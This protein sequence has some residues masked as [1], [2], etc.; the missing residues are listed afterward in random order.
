MAN[1]KNWL[2]VLVIVLVFG[3]TVV[4]CDDGS[5]GSGGGNQLVEEWYAT[6]QDA[7]AGISSAV[8]YQFTSDGKLWYAGTDNKI[9]YTVSGNTITVK[10]NGTKVGTTTFSISD[11]KLD[12]SSNC[13]PL[14]AGTYYKSGY[15]VEKTLV[16]TG[17]SS[18]VSWQITV[19]IID[20]LNKVNVVA[21]GQGTVSGGTVTIQLISATTYKPF[22][23]TGS[24]Y[25]KLLV[26]NNTT[27]FYTGGGSSPSKYH[28][29]NATTTI[30][31]S[32]L[33]K[34]D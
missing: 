12:I 1:R 28:L 18:S 24:F 8:I 22:I 19:G 25:I 21:V 20:N 17:I 3:M 34:Q 10:A 32:Q 4:G 14:I 27:Y 2:G 6:Q 23:G 15:G 31:F 7:D 30:P 16:I 11:T 5:G 26:N 33:S 29:T 9:T 13:P